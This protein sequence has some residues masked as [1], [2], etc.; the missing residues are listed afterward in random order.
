MQDNLNDVRKGNNSLR[1]FLG[2]SIWTLAW[3]I[4]VIG[5]IACIA[6]AFTLF[7][8]AHEFNEAVESKNWPNVPGVVKSSEPMWEHIDEDNHDPQ[9][10]GQTFAEIQYVYQINGKRFTNDGISPDNTKW[11]VIGHDEGGFIRSVVSQYSAGQAVKVYYNPSYPGQ[12]YLKP[13]TT[14][15]RGSEWYSM[16]IMGGVV[17]SGG[18]F[19]T[20][21]GLML[22]RY[23][24]KFATTATENA[25]IRA[26]SR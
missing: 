11:D 2:F 17:V 9:D 6:G 25:T 20:A 22:R 14:F 7:L 8:T 16:T 24:T 21:L 19:V 12:S 13:G 26:E 23:A 10:P 1:R 15:T 3:T 5:V 18:L 4:L